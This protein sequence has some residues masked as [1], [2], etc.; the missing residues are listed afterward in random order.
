MNKRQILFITGTRA[1]FGKM[2]QLMLAVD[3][4]PDFECIVFVTGMHMLQLYGYTVREVRKSGFSH[5]HA[6]INQFAGEPMELVLAN[7]IGGLSRF[8]SENRPDMMVVHGDRC[9]TLA[10]AITGSVRNILVAHIE[11]GEVSGTIDEII[12]HA[13]TKMSH[14]HFVASKKAGARLCQLGERRETIHVV[15]SPGVDVMMS[16]DLPPLEDVRE[17]YEISFDHY[18]IL[19]FHPVTTEL[20]G[21]YEQ[22]HD[23]VDVVKSSGD[24]YIVIFPNNDPGSDRILHEYSR[25]GDD[26]RFR[27][28]PSL[29]FEYFLTLLKNSNFIIGNSSAGVRE[30]PYYGVPTV[31]IGTRQKNRFKHSSI[32]DTNYGWDEIMSGIVQARQLRSTEPSQN[33]GRGESVRLFM[34]ILR[35]DATWQTV[36]QKHFNDI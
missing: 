14:I 13:V 16:N 6:F 29:R 25:L 3:T 9:E 12:R 36:P 15:G 22:A 28:F 27:L 35:H 21:L 4:S 34:E 10:G 20:D 11:G 8:V 5:I 19:I 23:L 31:N 26:P 18:S 1:D 30:A 33:F 17:R 7:T 32:I 2:K 24:N